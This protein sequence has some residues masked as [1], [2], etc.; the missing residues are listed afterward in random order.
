MYN[1]LYCKQIIVL[2]AIELV[3]AVFD[4]VGSGYSILLGK[5][6]EVEL[7]GNGLVVRVLLRFTN[8]AN[9]TLVS[10]GLVETDIIE[11]LAF[12]LSAFFTQGIREFMGSLLHL[13][14]DTNIF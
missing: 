1:I 12:V 13:A 2:V 5:L 3:H 7:E 14:S 9:E 11:L 4:I 10:A 8:G 6:V